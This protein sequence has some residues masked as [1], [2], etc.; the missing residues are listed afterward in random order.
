MIVTLGEIVLELCDRCRF[1]LSGCDVII[2][3]CVS[4]FL[5]WLGYSC[6]TIRILMMPWIYAGKIWLSLLN[7]RLGLLK[8]R[9]NWRFGAFWRE[10]RLLGIYK[11]FFKLWFKLSVALFLSLLH[12]K[13]LPTT[14]LLFHLNW[15]RILFLFLPNSLYLRKPLIDLGLLHLFLEFFNISFSNYLTKCLQAALL[16]FLCI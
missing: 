9:S 8:N 6:L 4:L 3:G 12:Y 2:C 16:L 10:F 5:S 7:C 15:I 14:C 11:F 13:R 1:K